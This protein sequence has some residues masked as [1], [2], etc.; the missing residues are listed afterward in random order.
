MNEIIR[1]PNDN[2]KFI[3][4]LC[5]QC[6]KEMIVRTDYASKHKGFCMSCLKNGNH[7]ASKHNDYKSRLYHIWLGLPHRRY[8]TYKPL[9]CK[10]WK[11][12]YLAFKEWAMSHG[13]EETLTIDRI[14][15]LGDYTP[16]NCRWI[17]LPDNAR[18]ARSLFTEQQKLLIYGFRKYLGL[19]QKQ[20]A[21]Q[22]HVS[23]HVIQNIERDIKNEYIRE[24]D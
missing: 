22:L 20:A 3:R 5:R 1:K 15:S 24:I 23:R 11:N 18:L 4:M 17:T 9:V 12:N 8:K 16:D 14:D 10:E 21:E 6:N 7:Y 13:Y 19:T 2:H